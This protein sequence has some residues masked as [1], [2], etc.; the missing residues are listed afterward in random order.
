MARQTDGASVQESQE[1]QV[2][3]N[4]SSTSLLVDQAQVSGTQGHAE[5]HRQFANA[6]LSVSYDLMNSNSRS[7]A[8]VDSDGIKMAS[9]ASSNV[10]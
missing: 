2:H 4:I 10:Q 6:A 9:G 1:E 7:L 5:H 3:R 8:D